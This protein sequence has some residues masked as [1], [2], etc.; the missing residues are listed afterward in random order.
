MGAYFAACF[1]KDLGIQKIIL[2]GDAQV[3]TTAIYNTKINM[4]R[5]GHIISNTQRVL[6][7]FGEWK[8]MFIRRDA[9]GT[10]H[11]LTNVAKQFFM[12]KIWLEKIPECIH[13]VILKEKSSL[14]VD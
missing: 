2:E 10:A 7:W 5:F 13:D 4:S 12:D 9:K 11:S 3:V 14:S 6:Q 8:C 1:C